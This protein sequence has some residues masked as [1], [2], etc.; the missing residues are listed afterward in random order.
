MTCAGQR[1]G[2]AFIAGTQLSG[3]SALRTCILHPDTTEADL[4]ILLREIRAAA[5]EIALP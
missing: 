2:H 3:T 1:R 4:D 5:K